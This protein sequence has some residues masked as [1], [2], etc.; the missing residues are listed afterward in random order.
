MFKIAEKLRPAHF[1]EH[2]E[3]IFIILIISILS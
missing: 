3:K 1:F 2:S